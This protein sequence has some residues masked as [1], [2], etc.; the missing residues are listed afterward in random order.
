MS[1]NNPAA[2]GYLVSFVVYAAL[3]WRLT[4]QSATRL[5]TRAVWVASAAMALWS[6]AL[7]FHFLGRPSST[8]IPVITEWI[9]NFTWITVL[10]LAL[11]EV[12]GGGERVRPP[13]N[14]YAIVAVIISV[15]IAA[16]VALAAIVG[17]AVFIR[18]LGLIFAVA[19]LVLCEQVLRNRTLQPGEIYSYICIA[20]G[21]LYLF[22]FFE[23][24]PI[25][26]ISNRLPLFD[27]AGGWVAAVVVLPLLV[28]LRRPMPII[29]VESDRPPFVFHW[30][31]V[32][33]VAVLLIAL[34][35]ADAFVNSVG[36]SWPVVLWTVLTT[37]ILSFAVVLGVS[38]PLRGQV[39]VFLTKSFL[40]Y[41]YDYRREWLRFIGTLS[42]TGLERLP[43]TSVQAIARIVNSPAGVVWV[44]DEDSERFTPIGA[45]QHPLPLTKT[46]STDSS[47]VQFMRQRQ[48]VIDLTEKQRHPSR[49]G[50]LELD[51]W[52]ETPEEWW[53][54][55][56]M[57]LGNELYGF[58]ALQRAPTLSTLNFEDHDLLRTVGRHIAT[59]L[60]QAVSDRQLSE[61][62]QFSTYHRLSA[63]LMHDLNNLA[64]QLSLVVKNAE[65]HR[66][67]PKFIDDMIAT[68]AHSVSRM[69]RLLEQLSN[70]TQQSTIQK[71][72]LVAIVE[73]AISLSAQRK[74]RP[75]FVPEVEP[76]HVQADAERLCNVLEHLIRNAQ[77]ATDDD[78]SLQ[79]EVQTA[80]NIAAVHISD[81]GCG[82]SEEF[83]NE[84]LFRP[85]D[86]T[87]G[88]QSMGIGAYQAREYIRSLGGQ[89]DVEST[90]GAGTTF[91][92]QMPVAR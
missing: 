7:A 87:K 10:L 78:G 48:W 60:K 34:V 43:S 92:L 83:I 35:S 54:I 55:V 11:G 76:I 73:K 12:R 85:F 13:A 63:F 88:S 27:I 58:V 21:G 56:P 62:Q 49:Y 38:P 68:V 89:V 14:S 1:L 17:S 64:A 80:D 67:D 29:Q 84:R 75:S 24:I 9:R 71:V 15:L 22:E 82:M 61:A 47:L 46:F 33:T 57:L 36:G 39:R 2:I 81:T 72:N 41:K 6:T 23:N 52:F 37:A 31:S 53:I 3:I 77:D 45:W 59:H 42:E 91:I 5:L 30:L 65:K 70:A 44:I 90:P 32:L 18:I 26:T 19:I 66:R 79:I 40:R 20:G 16:L 8:S 86:S 50:D 25:E 4:R 69:N 74:P 51:S 28:V